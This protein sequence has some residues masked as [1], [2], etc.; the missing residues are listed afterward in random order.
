[1]NK[2]LIVDDSIMNLKVLESILVDSYTIDTAQSGVDAINKALQNPPSLILLDILMPHMD[3]FEVI[4]RLKQLPESKDIPVIFISGLDGS[5]HEE[6]GFAL[7]AVDYITRPFSPGIVK[8]RVN[9]HIQLS[10]HRKAIESL[11]MYDGLTGAYNRRAYDEFIDVEWRRA[12]REKTF[13][14]VAMLD[15]D[16]FK[17]YNDNYGHLLGDE[18]LK[19]LVTTAKTVLFRSADLFARFG[20]EEFVFVMPMTE[21]EGAQAVAARVLEEINMLKIPHVYSEI[22]DHI[23]VSIGGATIKPQQNDNLLDFLMLVDKML[24]QSKNNGRNR[25]S[26]GHIPN[27]E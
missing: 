3:G 23:T 24:Y 1:M 16:F 26:W 8:A 2:V 12:K 11:V 20:G 13:L 7:G 5:E 22:A 4:A 25:I 9:T 18:V 27:I 19:T 10:E 17:K 6:K 14:S 15:I 21:A